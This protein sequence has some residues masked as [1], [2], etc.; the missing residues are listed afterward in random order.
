M[1]DDHL[2]SV[3]IVYTCI[4]LHV[5]HGFLIFYL[6]ICQGVVENVQR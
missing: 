2:L 4:V 6:K 3:R 5:L 1:L